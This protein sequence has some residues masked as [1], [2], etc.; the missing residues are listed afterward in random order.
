MIKP[1]IGRVVWYHPP[2]VADKDEETLPAIV[3]YVHSDECVNLAV[4]DANGLLSSQRHVKLYQGEGSRPP[5]AYA[6]WMP[7]QIAQAQKEQA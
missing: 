3:C 6:E 4:F 5:T 7:Y 1:T 2:F